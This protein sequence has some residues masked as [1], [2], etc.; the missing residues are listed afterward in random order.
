MHKHFGLT[1]PGRALS[2]SLVCVYAPRNVIMVV[3]CP[4]VINYRAVLST[5]ILRPS[6]CSHPHPTRHAAVADLVRTGHQVVGY[7]IHARSEP[8]AGERFVE[9]DLADL[10]KVKEVMAGGNRS[11]MACH[12]W[13]YP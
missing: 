11:T 2:P 5:G 8:F 10:E 6:C 3:G 13:R 1:V 4:E 7:D 12:G 9:G